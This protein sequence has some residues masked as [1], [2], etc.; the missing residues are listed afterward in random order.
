MQ[1]HPTWA[2]V[3]FRGMVPGSRHKSKVLGPRDSL[4]IYIHNKTTNLITTRAPH[5]LARWFVPSILQ[6]KPILITEEDLFLTH[7][8]NYDA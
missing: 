3:R 1:H 2:L 7:S 5:L 8:T 4:K 6:S